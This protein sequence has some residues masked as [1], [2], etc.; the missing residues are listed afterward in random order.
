MR[1]QLRSTGTIRPALKFHVRR[2]ASQH[3]PIRISFFR[4]RSDTFPQS[5]ACASPLMSS[6]KKI[7]CAIKMVHA[8]LGLIMTSECLN[9]GFKKLPTLEMMT[10]LS[11]TLLGKYNS[12]W[13]WI[14]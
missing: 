2:R 9:N 4:L 8:K 1:W 5:R 14:G 10:L 13:H 12:T 11:Q 7:S 6:E 3:R